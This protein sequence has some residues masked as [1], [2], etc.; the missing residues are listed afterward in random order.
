MSWIETDRS[1]SG[2]VASWGRSGGGSRGR[3]QLDGKI[4]APTG[5]WRMWLVGLDILSSG[6][7]GALALAPESRGISMA[8]APSHA[9]G[10]SEGHHDRARR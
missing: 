3:R 9:C 2:I 8:R 6:V 1:L 7:M 5:V 10:A 4:K